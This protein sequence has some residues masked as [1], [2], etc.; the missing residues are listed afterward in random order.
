MSF[1]YGRFSLIVEMWLR[2]LFR[3]W[4][5]ILLADRNLKSAKCFANAYKKS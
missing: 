5:Q 2:Q 3:T 4:Y 1:N